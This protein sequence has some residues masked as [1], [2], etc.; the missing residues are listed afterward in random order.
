M[1]LSVYTYFVSMFTT[2]MHRTLTKTIEYCRQPSATCST[3]LPS[4]HLRP[5]CLFSRRSHSLELSPGFH[6][7]PDQQCRVLQTFA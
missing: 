4:Q 6:P 3:S 5:P 2:Y 1:S 7:G